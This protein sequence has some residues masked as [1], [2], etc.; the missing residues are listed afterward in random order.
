[1]ATFHDHTHTELIKVMSGLVALLINQ[2]TDSP[3][4]LTLL[5]ASFSSEE[6]GD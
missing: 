4:D 1:M 3:G 5:L 2:L 6:N